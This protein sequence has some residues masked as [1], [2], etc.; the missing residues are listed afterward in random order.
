MT[1]IDKTFRQLTD[2]LRETTLL[3]S[4]ESLLGWD[5]RTMLPA[6]RGRLPGGAND[7]LSRVAP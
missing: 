4:I 2:H 5:E 6:A 1:A 3:H 7:T